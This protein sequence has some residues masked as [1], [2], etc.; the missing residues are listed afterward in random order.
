MSILSNLELIRRVPLF[1]MLTVRQAE[2]IA[3]NVTKRRFPRGETIVENGQKSNSLFII[4]I[5][6]Y[7]KKNYFIKYFF[8]K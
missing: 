6:F 3:A 7:K 2:L 8:F 1:S 4:F 5:N